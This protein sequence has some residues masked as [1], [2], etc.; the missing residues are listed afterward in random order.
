[1]SEWIF[2]KLPGDDADL[3]GI[4]ELCEELFAVFPGEA[5]C[6]YVGDADPGYYIVNGCEMSRV[7]LSIHQR[8]FSPDDEISSD[9]SLQISSK[10]LRNVLAG[11]SIIIVKEGNLLWN[12]HADLQKW[13]DISLCSTSSFGASGGTRC[14]SR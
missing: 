13:T 10:F 7:E 11:M 3:C 5:E 12:S 1:M 4:A 14:E 6:V 8:G 2:R 9:S